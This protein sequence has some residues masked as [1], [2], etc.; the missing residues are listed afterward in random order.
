MAESKFRVWLAQQ[1]ATKLFIKA[2]IDL[3][4]LE[5][6]QFK[7]SVSG[8]YE[9]IKCHLDRAIKNNKN[10]ECNFCGWEGNIFYPH[11]TTSGVRADEKCPICHSIPRYRSLMKFLK[12]NFNIFNDNLKILEVGPNRSLQDILRNKSNI[13]YISVDLKSPQAMFHMDV[14]DLK[15]ENEK[16]DLLFCV[17]V[18]QYVDD[19]KKGFEEMYR[20]LKPNG[21]LIFASGVNEKSNKTVRYPERIAEHN[22]TTREYGWDVKDLIEEVGFQ[23]KLFNPYKDADEVERKKFGLGEHTIF[24]LTK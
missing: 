22:F 24:L 17:G 18:M 7:N 2:F 14:T 13:D 20:V 11:V 9:T 10:V 4:Q 16:F 19:D 3:A 8:F 15:F 6:F 12:E 5:V 1:P 23:I 21:N